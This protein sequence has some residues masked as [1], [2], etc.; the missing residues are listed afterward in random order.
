MIDAGDFLKGE[1]LLRKALD[2]DSSNFC[3]LIFLHKVCENIIKKLIKD[4]DPNKTSAKK[5]IEKLKQYTEE[6]ERLER[7]IESQYSRIAILSQ[8]LGLNYSAH[9]LIDNDQTLSSHIEVS[10][11]L[12]SFNLANGNHT[13]LSNSLLTLL[14]EEYSLYSS[15][16]F[17][18]RNKDKS[19]CPPEPLNCEVIYKR[20]SNS[21]DNLRLLA[22][23]INGY[24]S[25]DLFDPLKFAAN[26]AIKVANHLERYGFKP[27][28]LIDS[29]ASQL[30]IINRIVFET[31]ISQPADTFI[32]Y[33]AGH[34][35][36]DKNGNRF[37][38]ANG[39][40]SSNKLIPVEMMNG[41]LQSHK[42]KVFVI[43][44]ACFER[45]NIDLSKYL[46]GTFHKTESSTNKIS[47]FYA[48]SKGE[49]AIESDKLKGGIATYTLIDYLSKNIDSIDYD[50]MFISMKILTSE[51][52][53][54]LYQQPQHPSI[55]TGANQ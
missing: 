33:L 38:V 36:S 9:F 7:Q 26:D 51:L 34:G 49:K 24:D 20:L 3:A 55:T 19:I 31:Y 29:Q 50:E 53:M 6:I 15:K 39:M 27:N 1:S 18:L 35:L 11:F 23:G 25:S 48:S 47:V 41:L 43:I 46:N 22:I 28:I 4:C 54:D 16:E 40:N 32:L 45:L 13:P 37:V 42:G 12:K 30:N 52:A 21:R 17:R 10:K 5:C 14:D 44:D 8:N 2:L